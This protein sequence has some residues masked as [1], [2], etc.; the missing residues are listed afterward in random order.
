MYSRPVARRA[1]RLIPLA[2]LFAANT[3]STVRTGTCG[4]WVSISIRNDIDRKSDPGAVHPLHL[5]ASGGY[6][7]R[8]DSGTS[9]PSSGEY[10]LGRGGSAR[11]SRSRSGT[12]STPTTSAARGAFDVIFFCRNVL[13]Y[14]TPEAAQTV[15]ARVYPGSGTRGA[16]VPRPGRRPRAACPTT[17]TLR[18][19]HDAFYYQPPPTQYEGTKATYSPP[20]GVPPLVLP[21]PDD[22]W[23]TAIGRASERIARLSCE[24]RM[25]APGNRGPVPVRGGRTAERE[26]PPTG[27]VAAREMIR[28]ERYADAL[29][30]L[31]ALTDEERRDPDAQLLRAVSLTNCGQVSEAERLCHDVLTGDELNAEAKQTSMRS[32]SNTT[33]TTKP[34]WKRTE[35][36]SIWTRGSRCRTCTSVSSAAARGDRTGASPWAFRHAVSSCS[37]MRTRPACC[38]SAAGSVAN[39]SSGLCEAELRASEGDA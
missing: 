26:P 15:V 11:R 10:Q 16:L 24:S 12:C 3:F 14:F 22:S 28:Q 2:I 36:R 8:S 4:L 37:R 21:A 19:A 31:G 29:S 32:V 35:R 27:L 25:P 33:G 23:V 39:C 1:K 7:S 6:R 9:G 5:V 18:H 20:D 34:R 30:V 38:F 17:S 13:M